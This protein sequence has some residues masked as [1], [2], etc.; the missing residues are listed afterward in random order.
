MKGLR[1]LLRSDDDS[2]EA[3]IFGRNFRKN[4][5]THINLPG[6]VTDFVEQDGDTRTEFDPA[7]YSD[8]DWNW[9]RNVKSRKK[10][11][12]YHKNVSHDRQPFRTSVVDKT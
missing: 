3:N 10:H 2:N 1:E 7:N 4:D 8:N 9:K 5:G 11:D 6:D 12:V